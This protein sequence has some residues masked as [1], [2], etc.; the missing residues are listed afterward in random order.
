MLFEEIVMVRPSFIE[1]K[2][3]GA[4]MATPAQESGYPPNRLAALTILSTLA[5]VRKQ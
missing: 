5:T 4:C 3:A 1:S 2:A